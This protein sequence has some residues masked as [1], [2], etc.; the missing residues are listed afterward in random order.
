MVP[1]TRSVLEPF[2]FIQNNLEWH[3]FL[4]KNLENVQQK[5]EHREFGIIADLDSASKSGTPPYNW[6]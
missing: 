5:F 2:V 4:S 3:T 6:T 1:R